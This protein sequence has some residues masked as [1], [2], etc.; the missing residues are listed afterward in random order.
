MNPDMLI[1]YH[2]D[3]D[4]SGVVPELVEMGVKVINP[5][6]PDCMGRVG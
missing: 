6:Q 2:S 1:F 3:G 4:F 5:L